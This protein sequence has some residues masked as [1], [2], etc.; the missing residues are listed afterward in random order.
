VGAHQHGTPDAWLQQTGVSEA[1]QHAQ[2]CMFHD[3]ATCTHEC[4]AQLIQSYHV[5]CSR[6]G[7]RCPPF[8]QRPCPL[9][10]RTQ[11]ALTCASVQIAVLA[12]QIGTA[13]KCLGNDRPWRITHVFYG[14]DCQREFTQL[15]I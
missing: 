14:A 6:G 9:V 8:G 5:I 13:G 1:L 12:V 4:G 7:A 10:V 3:A 11:V 2:R 15:G